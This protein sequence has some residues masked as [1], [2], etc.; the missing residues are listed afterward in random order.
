MANRKSK[1][2]RVLPKGVTERKDGR[3]LYRYSLYGKTCY[4]YD[5][6]LNELKKKIVELNY[7]ILK[8][9]RVDMSKKRYYRGNNK[10]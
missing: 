6:D 9:E 2:G 5:K 10:W 8:G 4:L 1:S 3:F 7:N